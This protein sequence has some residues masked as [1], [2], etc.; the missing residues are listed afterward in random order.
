MKLFRN[1]SKKKNIVAAISG[2]PDSLAL[3]AF[4]TFIVMKTK[5]R[6]FTF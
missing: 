1:M 2:G 6:F 4:V 5:I 3:A